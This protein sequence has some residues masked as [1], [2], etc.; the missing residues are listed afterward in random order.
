MRKVQLR[1][2]TKRYR[3]APTKGRSSFGGTANERGYN[4]KW[5]QARIK[6]LRE[7][8]FCAHCWE[9]GLSV[10]STVVDHIIPHRGDQRLFWDQKNW[11][12]LCALC[13][14]SWKQA[15]EKGFR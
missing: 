2:L 10:P 7:H 9:N 14:N 15:L 3:D 4:Y 8:P 6:F 12:S 11:N 13:H 5:Q 1:P